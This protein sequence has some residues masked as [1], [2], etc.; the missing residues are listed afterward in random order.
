MTLTMDQDVVRNHAAV[1]GTAQAFLDYAVAKGNCLG[2]A[3]LLDDSLPPL[4][5]NYQYPLHSWPW[6]LGEDMRRTL[7]ECACLVPA[8]VHRAIE[9]EFAGDA[10][11]LGAYFGMVD[12][13][14]QLYMDIRFDPS[15][16]MHRMDAMLTQDG[17]KIMEINVG[18]NIG[19][20]QIQWMDGLYRKHP[21]L[22]P[23]FD[24]VRCES[25]HIPLGY[26]GHLIECARTVLDRADEDIHAFVLVPA[27]FLDI[28]DSR[29]TMGD[30]FQVALKQSGRAGA[31][32]FAS[33]Y[34]VLDFTPTGVHF[35]GQRITVIASSFPGND[36]PQPPQMLYRAFLGG[37]LAWPD[38][39]FTAT[40]GDKRSLA[41]LHK[42]KH[43]PVF[44][45]R[46][47][48]L[49]DYFI[50]WGTEA[51]PKQVEFKGRQ[52][53]LET[54]LR[55]ERPR[56]VVKVAHGAQG[57]DVYVGKFK[58]DEEWS[59]AVRRAMSE[60]GWLVQEYC[61]SLPFYGQSGEWGYELHDVIWGVFGFGTQYGGCWLRLMRRG[62]GDGIINSAKGA[63]ET[64]VYE[65]VA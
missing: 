11:R 62:G 28:P 61:G 15:Q 56:F 17:L 6:F 51:T 37:R 29:K 1:S 54:L 14:A 31:M 26:M 12:L 65:V 49:I 30:V 32:H 57:N 9:L 36:A 47:R 2:P 3:A 50:P 4:F 44:S 10:Q 63:Q 5:R 52:A 45:E 22:Q 59:V 23:F 58:T 7:E 13:L 39:P 19:G 35:E 42:H 18:S 60:P 64:I 20:W 41:L 25:K 46:E 24:Q 16:V 34:D 27:E 40:I 33:S 8:L 48:Q 55:E 21:S 43:N 38:N 53:D